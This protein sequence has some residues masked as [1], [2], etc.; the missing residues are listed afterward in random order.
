M[1]FY[2]ATKSSAMERL[3]GL[4]KIIVD[5][6]NPD[7]RDVF[8]IIS[9][10]GVNAVPIEVAME[11]KKRGNKVIAVTSKAH[12]QNVPSRH[13]SGKKLME[14]ADVVLDNCGEVGDVSIKIPGLGQGLGPTSTIT[15]AYL[16]HAVMV[17]VASNLSKSMEPPVFWSANIPGGIEENKKIIERYKNRIR[18]W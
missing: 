17:Q 4:G 7:I 6:V 5:Y 8:T 18:T 9:N 13:S 3:E 15:G 1:A 2:G 16:L 14:V 10:S 11:A 12:S